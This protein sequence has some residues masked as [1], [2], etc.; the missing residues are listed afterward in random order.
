MSTDVAQFLHALKEKSLCLLV[1]LLFLTPL[2]VAENI[3]WTQVVV[4]FFPPVVVMGWGLQPRVVC[5]NRWKIFQAFG[6]LFS[7]LINTRCI[8]FSSPAIHYL[9]SFD[10]HHKHLTTPAGRAGLSVL[11][12]PEILFTHHCNAVVNCIVY[13]Y[14]I[15]TC[16]S[17]YSSLLSLI[18]LLVPSLDLPEPW[19][20]EITLLTTDFPSMSV[21]PQKKCKSSTVAQGVFIT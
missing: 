11:L 13:H 6:W 17:V 19:D 4:F 18:P 21:D 14:T 8:S 2:P 15:N 1:W 10:R 3:Y 5:Q 12:T 20:Q 7:S 16:H 9:R